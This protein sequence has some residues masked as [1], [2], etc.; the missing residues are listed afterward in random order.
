MSSA[1]LFRGFTKSNAWIFILLAA[2][3]PAQSF[4]AKWS[5]QFVEFE[6]PPQWSC[7]LEGAEWVCQSMNEEKK[8]DAIIVLAA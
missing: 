8:R 3:V 6:M 1:H 2:I 7:S 4:A 5:N